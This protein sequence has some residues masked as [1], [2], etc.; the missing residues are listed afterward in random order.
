M[1]AHHTIGEN[2]MGFGWDLPPGVSAA[3]IDALFMLD[4]GPQ[5][6]P[7]EDVEGI[8]NANLLEEVRATQK[9]VEQCEYSAADARAAYTLGALTGMLKGMAGLGEFATHASC[10]DA[11]TT[12]AVKRLLNAIAD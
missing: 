9:T 1:P 10:F 12:E 6:P 8:R 4:D 11:A 2:I 5:L 7:F 3:D